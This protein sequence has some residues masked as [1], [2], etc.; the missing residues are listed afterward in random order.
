M[1]YD[2]HAMGG[3]AALWVGGQGVKKSWEC[4]EWTPLNLPHTAAIHG[5]MEGPRSDRLEGPRSAGAWG[6][7]PTSRLE[8]RFRWDRCGLFPQ[9]NWHR[10]DSNDETEL[11]HLAVIIHHSRSVN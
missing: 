8:T 6:L 9:F 7:G 4:G 2:V 11:L 10:A 1:L 5:P 3:V